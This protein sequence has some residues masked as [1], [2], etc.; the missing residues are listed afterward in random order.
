MILYP[1]LYLKSVKEI[2]L[3]LLNKYNLK[4]LILDVDNTLISYDKNMPE[5]IQEW[6]KQLKH[7]NICLC[8]VSNSNNKEKVAN[9]AKKLDIPYIYF[10]MKP[11]KNGFKKAKE[12]L[13]LESNQIGVVGDQVLTDV[14]GANRM[15]MFSI[16]VEPIEEKD[17][18]ITRLKR[19]LENKIVKKYKTCENKGAKNVHK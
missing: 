12:I 4:S 8:I 16:L 13:N 3:E 11:F 18:W 5:G 14:V 6:I 1:K 10:A 7:A 9:V 19:P 2:S 17:I 15:G